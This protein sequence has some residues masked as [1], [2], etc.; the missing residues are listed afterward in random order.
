[1]ERPVPINAPPIGPPGTKRLGIMPIED[2]NPAIPPAAKPPLC[3][4][5]KSWKSFVIRPPVLSPFSSVGPNSLDLSVSDWVANAIPAPRI[6]PPIGPPGNHKDPTSPREEVIPAPA[7][8]IPPAAK[9]PPFPSISVRKLS[10]RSL[11]LFTFSPFEGFPNKLSTKKEERSLIRFHTSSIALT[12]NS[13]K[14]TLLPSSFS[15]IPNLVAIALD[16][17]SRSLRIA[18][19]AE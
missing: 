18:P 9:K 14:V 5:K 1:M 15:P 8:S 12:A 17:L 11:A 10:Y 13:A 2:A 3:S 4:L 19:I 6:A 7:P 16:A